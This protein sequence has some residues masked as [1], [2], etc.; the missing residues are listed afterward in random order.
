MASE[1]TLKQQRFVQHYVSNGGN[2]TK[3]VLESYDTDDPDYAAVQASRLI[4]NEKVKSGIQADLAAENINTRRIAAKLNRALDA[5]RTVQTADGQVLGKTDDWPTILRAVD[6]TAKL[7]ALYPGSNGEGRFAQH[8]HQHVH[9]ESESGSLLAWI[10]RNKRLP[11]ESERAEIL[12][13]DTQQVVVEAEKAEN[14][15]DTDKLES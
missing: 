9:L 10:A 13:P 15:H 2:G 5:E 12:A 14:N 4:R 7:L 8:L 3:A 1:L 6:I 11:S